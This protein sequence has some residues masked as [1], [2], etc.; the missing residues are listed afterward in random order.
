MRVTRPILA[1]V[2]ILACLSPSAIAQEAA[3]PDPAA[4]KEPERIHKT[5]EE[6]RR[7]LT[8]DQFLV[9]RMGATEPAFS[10]RYATGHF[11][12]TFLCVCCGAELFDSWTKFESGTGWPS[13][14]RPVNAKALERAWDRSTPELR[15]EVTCARCGAHLGHVFDDGPPPTGL[16]YCINSL[17]IK[18]DREPARSKTTRR[19]TRAAKPAARK[20]AGA[21]KPSG[22]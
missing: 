3:G 21:E 20:A 14:W 2:A 19:S 8:H 22:S 9:T 10:G 11:K 13:F 16:R 17:A 1:V 4:P 5:N 7:L 6:W 15:V 18:L 12:G